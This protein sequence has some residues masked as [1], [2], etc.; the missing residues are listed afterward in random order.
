MFFA[1]SPTRTRLIHVLS[2]APS[3]AKN[4]STIFSRTVYWLHL[5]RYCSCCKSGSIA[6]ASAELGAPATRPSRIFA[7]RIQPSH[8]RSSRFQISPSTS[9][10]R[11]TL[12]IHECRVSCFVQTRITLRMNPS[13]RLSF[14]DAMKVPLI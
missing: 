9:R 13:G 10:F 4:I 5:L 2:I 14:S 1:K 8:W 6:T 12:Q 3:F 11:S 7:H